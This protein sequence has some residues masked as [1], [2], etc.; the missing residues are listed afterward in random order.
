MAVEPRLSDQELSAVLRGLQVDGALQPV[1]DTLFRSSSSRVINELLQ[2]YGDQLGSGLI[3]R[4][5]QH[6]DPKVRLRAVE[7]L[8]LTKNRAAQQEALEL[9]LREEDADVIA[10]Y[11][12]VLQ[13][14]EGLPG[15]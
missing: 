14:E 4:V 2:Q 1:I 15:R 3:H 10:A 12:R 5:L 13:F 6:P 11:K 7:L 8:A 9:Y